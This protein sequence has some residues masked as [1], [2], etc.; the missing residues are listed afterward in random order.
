MDISCGKQKKLWY[1]KIN[2]A[3]WGTY[4]PNDTSAVPSP[5]ASFLA[6]FGK[7]ASAKREWLVTK[8]KGP[9]PNFNERETS[10]YA[11]Q[12]HQHSFSCPFSLRHN[13]LRHKDLT[14][15]EFRKLRWQ[16]LQIFFPRPRVGWNQHPREPHTSATLSISEDVTTPIYIFNILNTYKYIYQFVF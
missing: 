8:R 4:R 3:W 9:R 13:F 15:K 12:I 14:A 6:W 1:C 10:G 5:G 7:E 16:R 11:W 2:L